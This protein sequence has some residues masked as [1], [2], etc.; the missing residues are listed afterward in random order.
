MKNKYLQI[1]NS[2]K[3][4]LFLNPFNKNPF[5]SIFEYIGSTAEPTQTN[6]YNP[7]KEI[8][9][10][11]NKFLLYRSTNIKYKKLKYSSQAKTGMLFA[12]ISISLYSLFTF[13]YVLFS[14]FYL[15]SLIF[16]YKI[17]LHDKPVH[18]IYIKDLYLLSDGKTIQVNTFD[19]TYNYDIKEFKRFKLKEFMFFYFLSYTYNMVYP[20]EI[21]KKLFVI[22]PYG[23]YDNELFPVVM[24]SSYIH[25]D[26]RNTGRIINIELVNK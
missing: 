19:N 25:V 24:N 23:Y 21:G 10:E 8:I 7:K 3:H 26:E 4:K 2:I 1:K 6:L 18:K 9:F 11:N 12:T 20:I 5:P 15:S 16:Y 14:S 22:N 17:K 13:Q